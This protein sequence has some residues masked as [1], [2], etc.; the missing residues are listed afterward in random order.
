MILPD[1]VSRSN[2]DMLPAARAERLLAHLSKYNYA[3]HEHVIMRLLWRLGCRAGGLRAIDLRDYSSTEQYVEIKHR[4]E[5]GTPLKNGAKGERHVALGDR[6]CMVLDDYI[7][8]TRPDVTDDHSRSPLIATV[9]GRR[10]L[11]SLR[12]YSYYWSSPCRAGE[13]PHG[14]DPESCEAAEWM[15]SNKCP[16]SVSTHPIRRG[17]ITHHLSNDVPEVVVSDKMDVSL[18]VLDE[19][20]DERDSRG[21]M[22]QRRRYLDNI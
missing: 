11:Q 20:Y 16:S 7:D 17:A 13:C 14:R 18:A 1:A 9:H 15:H 2:E 22:E 3:S 21:R 8:S 6:T 5:T 12:R 4:P 10:S 19:H